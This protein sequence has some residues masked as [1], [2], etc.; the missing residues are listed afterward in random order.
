MGV[1]LSW[2]LDFSLLHAQPADEPLT[3]SKDGIFTWNQAVGVF[4]DYFFFYFYPV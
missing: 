2:E 3:I 1:K 4:T